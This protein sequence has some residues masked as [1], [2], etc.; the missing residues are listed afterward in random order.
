MGGFVGRDNI[1][2][3]SVVDEDDGVLAMGVGFVF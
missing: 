1:L 3:G 2:R